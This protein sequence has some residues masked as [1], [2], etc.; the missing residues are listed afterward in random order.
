MTEPEPE[1]KH[2]YVTAVNGR[3]HFGFSIVVTVMSVVQV[4]LGIVISEQE[5]KEIAWDMDGKNTNRGQRDEF[6]EWFHGDHVWIGFVGFTLAALGFSVWHTRARANGIML[7]I[8]LFLAGFIIYPVAAGLGG[9]YTGVGWS[10]YSGSQYQDG[11]TRLRIG[12]AIYT[13]V[14]AIVVITW[15][16]YTAFHACCNSK[17][18]T[19]TRLNMPGGQMLMQAPSNHQVVYVQQPGQQPVQY[20]GGQQPVQ[21][22]GG[23]Q[24]VQYTGGQ[25]PV[26]YTG[27]QQPVQYIGGQQPVQY[28]GG[29]QPVYVVQGP[30]QY[31]PQAQVP[32]QVQH[33]APASAQPEGG[34]RGFVNHQYATE[35]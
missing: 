28:M 12:S 35:Y 23:Q 1:P 21:Y 7:T 10:G 20:T 11:I 33:G 13:G 32:V 34:D 14:Q 19:Q 22:I 27:G 8:I 2:P 26:Q 30:P 6:D 16:F 29:Q 24:P 18:K 17:V 25:Q 9:G 15:A 4:I 5:V 31:V 3:V